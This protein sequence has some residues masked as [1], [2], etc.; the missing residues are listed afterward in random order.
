MEDRIMDIPV[1]WVM[2]NPDQPRKEFDQVEL[3]SLADSIKEH[4]QKVPAVVFAA[5]RDDECFTL[6]DGERRLRAVILAGMPTLKAIVLAEKPQKNETLVDAIIANSQCSDL[7]PIEEAESIKKLIKIG[8]KQTEIAKLLG[9]SQGHVS[10]R[11]RLLE[12]EPEIQGFIARKKITLDVMV[13]GGLLNLPSDTRISIARKFAQRGLTITGMRAIL[14]RLARAE[15]AGDTGSFKRLKNSPASEVAGTA[16][17]SMIMQIVAKEGV[18]PAWAMIE[19][20]AEETCQDCPLFEDASPRTCQG[21]AA[22]I[23][24]MKLARLAKA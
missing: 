17:D 20:A 6:I 2:P 5:D 1:D 23:L 7:N 12:L 3:Q 24:L 18:T 22:V 14:T 15:A 21:C 9:K 4:G 11:L 16:K 13:V 10:F 8:L 19:K